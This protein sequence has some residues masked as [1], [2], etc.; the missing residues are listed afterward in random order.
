MGTKVMAIVESPTNGEIYAIPFANQFAAQDWA[1]KHDN[2]I[3][4]IAI[5][6]LSNARAML[7]MIEKD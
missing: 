1:D 3:L 2:E 4:T 7:A 6:P 5:Y